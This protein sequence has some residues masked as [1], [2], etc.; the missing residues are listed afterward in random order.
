[1]REELDGD[2]DKARAALDRI[3]ALFFFVEDEQVPGAIRW[4]G[5][6]E[7]VLEV[8]ASAE[9]DETGR[10]VRADFSGGS[11]RRPEMGLE[12]RERHAP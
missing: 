7:P 11:R 4:K 10:F 3:S 2:E 8:A 6:A 9:L 1:V 5:V 12:P